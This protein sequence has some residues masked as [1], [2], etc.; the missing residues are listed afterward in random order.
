MCEM[1]P[2]QDLGMDDSTV[3]QPGKVVTAQTSEY[4]KLEKQ[5]TG[6]RGGGKR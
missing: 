3:S 6:H 1:E 2:V 5:V 4:S